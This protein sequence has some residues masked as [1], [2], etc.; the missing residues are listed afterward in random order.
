MRRTGYLLVPA[1]AALLFA[2]AGPAQADR[3]SFSFGLRDYSPGYGHYYQ[4]RHYG[5][6][7]HYKR[8]YRGHPQRFRGGHR[9]GFRRHGFRQPP[10]HYWG[11]RRD[12]GRPWRGW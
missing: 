10:R 6:Q 2:L 3:Y 11:G 12:H 8:Y 1:T 5:P 4:P 7:F 9:H